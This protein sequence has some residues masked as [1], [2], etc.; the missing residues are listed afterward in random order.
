[1][2]KTTPVTT[3]RQTI[4]VAKIIQTS[5]TTRPTVA[6]PAV[7][8]ALT[9]TTSKDQI[10]LKDLLKN[11]SL[12]E[13]MKLKPPPNIAQ[14]VATAASKCFQLKSISVRLSSG[15]IKYRIVLLSVVSRGGVAQ[16]VGN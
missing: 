14:P 16:T 11:N 12:N 3:T 6:A 1:M 15:W 13:L 4:T 2:T 8:N 7:Q 10:Q 5:T 9:T